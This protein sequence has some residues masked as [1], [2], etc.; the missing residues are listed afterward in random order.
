MFELI[1]HTADIGVRATG[2]TLEEMFS[3]AAVGM[4]SIIAEPEGCRGSVRKAVIAEGHDNE[5]LL[6]GFLSELLY[7]HEVDALFLTGFD[8]NIQGVGLKGVVTGCPVD[9]VE[10]LAGIK[11]VTFHR[12][13]VV[14]TRDS[15]VCEV[16]F[17][18]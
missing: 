5:S 4:F 8:L 18:I 6:H 7:I 16:L 12:L 3:E 1:E 9:E 2:R 10:V 15:W 13:T 17:D 14:Q 11:A